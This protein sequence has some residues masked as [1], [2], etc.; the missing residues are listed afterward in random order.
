MRKSLFP[1]LA[2]AL[3]LA[4]TACAS[5]TP[6]TPTGLETVTAEATASPLPLLTIP[7]LTPTD[8]PTCIALEAEPTPGPEEPSLF[9]PPSPEDWGRGP[10]DA[11]VTIIE[12]GDF[13]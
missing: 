13:Q 12:Y 4:L 11:T 9:A 3:L 2:P 6:G 8:A 1:I 5:A 7:A 10:E